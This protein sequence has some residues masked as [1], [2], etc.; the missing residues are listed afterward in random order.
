[1]GTFRKVTHLKTQIIGNVESDTGSEYLFGFDPEDGLQ[2]LARS[3]VEY[4]PADKAWRE[5]DS[6]IRRSLGHQQSHQAEAVEEVSPRGE[7]SGPHTGVDALAAFEEVGVPITGKKGTVSKTVSTDYSMGTP[8]R[9]QQFEA[10]GSMGA[11][12]EYDDDEIA[13]NAAALFATLED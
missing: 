6:Y 8:A 10:V 5:A 4:T 12:E 2:W 9:G 13:D 7:D 11:G 1:M 3:G